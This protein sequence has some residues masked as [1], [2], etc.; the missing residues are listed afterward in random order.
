MKSRGKEG[1]RERNFTQEQFQGSPAHNRQTSHTA[2]WTKV[3]KSNKTKSSQS[4]RN[5]LPVGSQGHTG[6]LLILTNTAL[7]WFTFQE[8]RLLS[9][10]AILFLS[11]YQRA[12][13]KAKASYFSNLIEKHHCTPKI[14]SS[15]INSA[16]NPP[17]NY[18]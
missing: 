15:V 11:L 2:S 9:R 14:L 5:C 8:E 18:F 12:V 10:S 4:E 1:E 7:H 16:L 17:T 6:V 3:Q 13:K